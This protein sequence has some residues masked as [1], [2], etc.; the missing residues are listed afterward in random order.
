M[1]N[2][3]AGAILRGE[4]M[5]AGA[6][7]GLNELTLSNAMYLS[8]WTDSTI[9]LPMDEDLFYEKLKALQATSKHKVAEG[10]AIDASSIF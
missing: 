10:E 9:K 8:S 4:K 3:F 6:E 5:Y 1:L 2:A 7:D